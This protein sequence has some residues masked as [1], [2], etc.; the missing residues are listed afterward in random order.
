MNSQLASWIQ[1]V[2]GAAQ[3]VL[4]FFQL[5][6]KMHARPRRRRQSRR[7]WKGFGIEYSRHDDDHQL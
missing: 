4:A 1:I 5:R 3:L 6:G 7:H 2:I